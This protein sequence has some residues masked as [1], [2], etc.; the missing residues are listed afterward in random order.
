MPSAANLVAHCAPHALPAYV[1]AFQNGDAALAAAGI[2]TPLRLAHFLAQILLECG[3]GRLEWEDMTHYSANRIDEVFGVGHHSA[4]V[5]PAEAAQL[6]GDGPAL[7]ER[8]YGL[9]NPTK[10]HDLGNTQPG[11]GFRFRG[12]GLMQTTGRGNYRRMSVPG[13]VDFEATPTA[14]ISAQFA[15]APAIKEWSAGNLNMLADANCIKRIT[16]VIN[17]GLNGFQDRCDLFAELWPL[18]SGQPAVPAFLDYPDDGLEDMQ[19]DL[20]RLHANPQLVVDGKYGRGSK[21]AIAAFQHANGLAET[22][23]PNDETRAA[24]QAALTGV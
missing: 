8:V 24:I 22:G 9:G 23:V 2:D 14:I 10:A 1:S 21:A 5:T 6:A 18:A 20:N 16:Q 15:L 11:D 12:G 7:A 3:R 17:G 4:N 13:V 19:R